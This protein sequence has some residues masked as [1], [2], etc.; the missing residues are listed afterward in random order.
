MMR[1]PK[2]A[3]ALSAAAM[4][5]WVSTAVAQPSAEPPTGEVSAQPAPP[6]GEDEGEEP[7]PLTTRIENGITDGGTELSLSLEDA[8]RM[9]VEN[10]LNV[11]IARLDD[12]IRQRDVVFARSAFDPF[13]NVSAT[14]AKNRDPTV[15]FLDVGTGAQGV[16]VNPSE[17]TTY[18][19]GVSGL[20]VLG[21]S[22]DFRVEQ[23][24]FDRPAA[25]SGGITV[26]NPVTRT[27]AVADLR[28]PLLRGAWYAVNSA[29]LRIALNQLDWSREA[30]E[31]V[32][33]DTVYQ[34]EAAYWD[35]VFAV[36]NY[37]SIGKSL[38]VDL[39]NL[40]NARKRLEVG[41]YSPNDVTVAEAQWVLRKVTREQAVLELLVARDR[42]LD[43]VN[44]S[45]ERSLVEGW[46]AGGGK[47]S[48]DDVEIILETP[49]DSELPDLD[50]DT[51]LANAMK[52]RA[53]YRQV[54][55]ELRNQ[56][57][58]VE[59]A[60]NNLLPQ[61]DLLGRWTQLGLDDTYHESY[62]SVGD[63]DF[64]DWFVGVELSVPLSN[65]GPRSRY[66]NARE[67]H[68]KLA[69][70][71]HSLENQVALEVAAAVREIEN[72]RRRVVDRARHVELQTQLVV[73]ER[74]KLEAGRTIAYTVS[75]IENDL[76]TAETDALRAQA[77][78]Q[79]AKAEYYRATGTLLQERRIWVGEP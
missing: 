60:R 53:D 59:V 46:R 58:R 40:E 70:Q 21:T 28:Q 38:E 2:S 44:Y 72:L 6:T 57:I 55:V 34:V 66:R 1:L 36:Q 61:L 10:N 29:D 56:K 20:F 31:L 76:V 41:K 12:A 62:S 35:L 49:P 22:Y 51:A 4:L 11:R 77:D 67:E 39:E 26:L 45:G 13:F 5:F 43:L 65:R 54:L 18:S 32:V 42:L 9:A 23:N 52:H 71:K 33:I 79:K 8:I 7:E 17:I 30:F 48:Y 75:I 24:E 27:Q 16:T 74:N 3:A 50:I 25:A 19:T 78:L 68:R 63:G 14:Y 73:D 69:L 47:G 64:Y 15:S 37:R